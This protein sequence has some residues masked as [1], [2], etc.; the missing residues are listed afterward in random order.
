MSL[1]GME[2]AA[3]TEIGEALKAQREERRVERQRRDGGKSFYVPADLSALI[4][5]GIGIQKGR[6]N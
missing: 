1:F 4:P 5:G 2:W 3:G 6:E